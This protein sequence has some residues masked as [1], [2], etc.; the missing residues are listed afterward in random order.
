MRTSGENYFRKEADFKAAN[1]D[2][3]KVEAETSNHEDLEEDKEEANF[4]KNLNKGYW[5]MKR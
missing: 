4:L 2:K 5:Q 3:K 1:K